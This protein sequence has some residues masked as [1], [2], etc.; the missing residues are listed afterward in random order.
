MCHTLR[1]SFGL[2]VAAALTLAVV[3]PASAA[4]T[5]SVVRARSAAGFIATQQKN[6]GSIP[7]FSP[8]GSTADAVMS[9]VAVK[10]G[11]ITIKKALAYL[12]R[13]TQ[14]GNVVG[15]GLQ[16]KVAMAAVA[17]GRDPSSFGGEDL[18][19][20]IA[21]TELPNGRFGSGTA[22]FDQSLAI[23]ALSAAGETVSDDAEGWLA[24]AQCPDG[25]WEYL[26][27]WSPSSDDHCVSEVDPGND[28]FG[29]DTNTTSYAVQ[30]LASVGGDA[31]ANAPF[32][33]FTAIR[34]PQFGGW[35]YSWGYA[36]DANSTSLVVQAFAADARTVPAGAL[37]ALKKL[38][39]KDCGAFAFTWIPD[40]GDFVKSAPDPGATISAIV[41]LLVRPYPVPPSPVTKPAPSTPACPS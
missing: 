2:L 28:F 4:P 31:L 12:A 10:R 39:Y 37:A 41:G 8:V 27:R 30:A 33:F 21:S 23:L 24:E 40:G 29:S 36:T 32:D 13:Q 20:A 1:R 5:D 14:N 19:D 34:D 38:Q 15:I 26:A 11:P 35:G 7:A 9:L 18:I 6:N 17:G 3:S 22:V 25:G 16:A